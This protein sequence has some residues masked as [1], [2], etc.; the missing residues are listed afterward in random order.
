MFGWEFPP[1]NSGGLGVACYQLAEALTRAGVDVTFVLPKRIP[2]GH[3]PFKVQF[4][5]IESVSAVALAS[6]YITSQEYELLRKELVVDSY[7]FGLLE[8][9][10]RY[11]KAARAI[12]AQGTF[13]IIHAHDWLS[14][15][16]G[17]AAKEIIHKPL[18]SHIHATEFDRTGGHSINEAVYGIEKRGMKESDKVVTVSDFT[19][20]MIVEKYDI[21]E[22]KIRVIHNGI[23]QK[24]YA[25]V[26]A[27]QA[28]ILKLKQDG[29]RIV[30]FVG[31]LTLQKGPDYFVKVAQKILEKDENVFF[32][33][34]GSGDME[35]R[36]I[37]EVAYLGIGEKFIFTGFLRGREL[38][39]IYQIA[40]LFIMPSVSEP[41]GITSLEAGANGTPV[42]MSKQSGAGEVVRHV[43][44]ADFW[45]VDDMADKALS[46]LS[47]SALG[48][49][50]KKHNKEELKKLGWEK[51]AEKCIL[52][53]NE[54]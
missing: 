31:R 50:L 54:F 22:S 35:R 2:L 38:N 25:R 12:A 49:T 37:D 39:E 36:I 42:L 15:P 51:A 46:V 14:F 4:A 9:V 1:F 45:D 52:L 8:E 27:N 20:K 41:F 7:V 32:V 34:S 21:P 6:G 17:L 16:A 29:S 44:K 53:Y 10:A 43:L 23:N 19:K 30:I 5:N 24:D 47:H 40:D 28:E 13:D 48:A 26:H 33:V 11:G 18:I 3:T